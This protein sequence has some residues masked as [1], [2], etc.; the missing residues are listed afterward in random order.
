[1]AAAAAAIS[2]PG[3]DKGFSKTINLFVWCECVPIAIRFVSLPDFQP[4]MPSIKI[5]WLL[6][7]FYVVIWSIMSPVQADFLLF[8]IVRTVWLVYSL[9]N[10]AQL[11]SFHLLQSFSLLIPLCALLSLLS[12]VLWEAKI[13]KGMSLQEGNTDYTISS[14]RVVIGCCS[15]DYRQRSSTRFLFSF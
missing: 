3:K 6:L 12:S 5:V 1:M 8:T 4:P 7:C 13:L 2:N 11:S 15:T 10:A 14:S 9:I